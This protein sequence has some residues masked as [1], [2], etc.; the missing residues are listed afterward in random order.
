VPAIA[1]PYIAN[2][3][4][5]LLTEMGRQPW[6]VYGQML[7]RNAGSPMLNDKPWMVITS[8]MGFFLVYGLLAGIDVFLMFKYAKMDPDTTGILERSSSGKSGTTEV[9]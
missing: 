5:W 7:T 4:G 6:V 1:F 2:T 9:N 3:A 8:L